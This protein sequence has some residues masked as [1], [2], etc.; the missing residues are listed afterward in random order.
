MFIPSARQAFVKEL[1]TGLKNPSRQQKNINNIL[2]ESK[3][4]FVKVSLLF[5]DSKKT[6]NNYENINHVQFDEWFRVF[7]Q[8][9]PKLDENCVVVMNNAF[10]FYHNKNINKS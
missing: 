2:L 1:L 5:F 9:L 8:M 10:F 4:G 3:E 6:R 7:R